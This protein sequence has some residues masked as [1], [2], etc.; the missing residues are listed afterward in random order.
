MK[1][2]YLGLIVAAIFV[3]GCS[4]SKYQNGNATYDNMAYYK[5]TQYYSAYLTKRPND[6]RAMLKLA[7]SYRQ[8]HDYIRAEY[9][10][11][12]ALA[13]QLSDPQDMLNYA[14]VL[15][16]NGK[17]DQ[18]KQWFSQYLAHNPDDKLVRAQLYS[19][20]S[21]DIYTRYAKLYN[22]E[23]VAAF[24]N[25]SNFSMIP[26]EDGFV[27]NSEIPVRRKPKINPWNGRPYLNIM[28]ARLNS[29]EKLELP[30]SF[31]SAINTP[32]HNGP[33]AFTP[34]Y[35]RIYYSRSYTKNNRLAK[36]KEGVSNIKIYTAERNGNDW[37]NITEMPFNSADYS[38]GHPTLSEDGKTMYFIS[39]RPGT[40]GKTDI[41]TSSLVDGKWSE[42]INLGPNVNTPGYEM[43]P[44]YYRDPDGLTRLYF[45]SDG[46]PGMGGLDLYFIEKQP[47][48][49]WG[50][51]VHLSAP[52][53]SSKD[54]FSLTLK[55]NAAMGYFSSSRDGSGNI[56]KLYAFN[57][58]QLRFVV[59]GTVYNKANNHT[60]SGATVQMTNNTNGKNT[61][62]Y[63]QNDGTF[64]APLE[65]NSDYSFN[66]S[67]KSYLPGRTKASTIGRESDEVIKV[68]I[69]LDSLA[70]VLELAKIYYDFDKY[71]IRPDAAAQLDRLANILKE[72]P[73]IKLDLGAHADCRGTNE[74]N[75]RL[76]EKRARSAVEYLVAR[77]ITPYRLYAK[78][79]GESMP[80]NKCVD[81]VMCTEAEHQLNRRT[82]FKERDEAQTG[83][84]KK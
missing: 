72:N 73:D 67:K 58:D 33:V 16:M 57:K 63:S 78:W 66:A 22:V 17:Y 81:G 76:T 30:T 27:F 64:S 20:D 80:V 60:V 61:T 13:G 34:D 68:T 77:G 21:L 71:N 44:Y 5:A 10:Y 56:D 75:I 32:F 41:Y 11:E 74:Y 84:S 18:A 3:A 26:Y 24:G 29:N 7:D 70:D 62:L 48:G 15:K 40:L 51:P 36:D 6:R 1:Q 59:E 47:D 35:K 52:F 31:N 43:F 8:M 83:Y 69:Y 39:D 25:V 28:F 46:L 9:W 54:D 23:L 49:S 2:I 19:C 65:V 38:T 14:S 12:K 53:N 4:S 55:N 79:Y 50:S 37:V 45:S 82:E 42:P